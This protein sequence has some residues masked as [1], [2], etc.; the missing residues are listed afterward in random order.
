[1]FQSVSI[2]FWWKWRNQTLK[3]RHNW[4]LKHRSCG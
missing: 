4:C 3:V 2:T 1:M